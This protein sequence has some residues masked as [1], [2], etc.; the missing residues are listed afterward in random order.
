MLS[1]YIFGS[2]KSII[3]ASF[4]FSVSLSSHIIIYFEL[5]LF[6]DESKNFPSGIVISNVPLYL[7]YG[8]F[9]CLSISKFDNT[10]VYSSPITLFSSSNI[11]FVEYVLVI[12]S[13][14]DFQST[15]ISKELPSNVFLE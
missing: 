6:P 2:T 5:L 10:T 11:Y 8:S 4:I 15:L 7:V 12:F 3:V 13:P 9:T 1:V 14:T